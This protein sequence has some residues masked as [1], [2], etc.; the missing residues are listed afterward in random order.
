MILEGSH[1]CDSMY[2]IIPFSFFSGSVW[3]G[4]SKDEDIPIIPL[5]IWEHQ[6]SMQ[7][8]ILD[9]QDAYFPKPPYRSGKFPA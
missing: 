7:T 2:N 4:G 5:E 9:E 8:R 3:D 1:I 6:Q